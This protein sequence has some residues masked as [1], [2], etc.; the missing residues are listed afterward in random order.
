MKTKNNIGIFSFFSGAGFLDLGFEKAGDFDVLFVNEIQNSFIET[1]KKTR[2]ALK[3]DEPEFGYHN[4]DINK[5]LN[6]NNNNIKALVNV[7]KRK[8]NFTG[9]IGGPPCPDFSVAGKNRGKNGENGKLTESYINIISDLQPD[10]FL[11]ENVKGLYRTSRHREFYNE[12]KF[13]LAE[14]GYSTTERLINALEYG[15]PQNRERILLIGFKKNL[16]NDLNVK[17]SFDLDLNF[18]WD[19][20]KKYKY[21]KIKHLNWPGKSKF[22]EN[23]ILPIPAN[24]IRE[25][26]VEFWF[27]RNDVKNHPN[28]IHGFNPR[29]GIIKF[30]EVDEGDDSK[31]S[32]KRLHR[33][34]YSPTVAYGNNEVHLHPYKPR[35]ITVAEALSLQ[36]LPKNFIL[37]DN[38]TLTDMFKMIGNGVPYLLSKN[39][40]KS[41]YT[42]LNG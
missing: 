7:A 12:M 20:N 16:L 28:S 39:I 22:E 34:R 6:G 10:F 21:K 29:T 27:E 24:I 9:F 14:N 35:R 8:Y 41:I 31:K 32:Y 38:V 25:L 36:S 40:A 42:F 5:F 3:I 1:Y 37:P 2:D 17:N 11:F 30:M 19:L 33:W 26:T 13:K 4:Y 18:P 15:V 23:S